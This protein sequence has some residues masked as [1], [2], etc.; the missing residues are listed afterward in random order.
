MA[1]TD[2]AAAASLTELWNAHRSAVS[3]GEGVYLTLRAAIAAGTLKPGD[4]LAEPPIAEALGISRTPIREALL[5]LE[6]Q[7]L[8]E[9]TVG[10]RLIV[11]EVTAEEIL[12]VY[13]VREVLTAL[14]AR[15]AAE[16][17]STSDQV[18]LRR[19]HREMRWALEEG[20]IARMATLNFE[21]HDTLC[22]A[23]RNG[24]LLAT[25]RS[26]HDTHQRYPGSTFS[27]PERAEQSVREHEQMLEAIAARDGDRAEKLAH[28]HIAG[29]REARIAMLDGTIEEERRRLAAEEARQREGGE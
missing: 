21:F 22:A 29:V 6:T 7:R 4:H 14:A 20:D 16:N 28:Q 11:S 9:R 24:F 2:P 1:A 5:R 23:S 8:V 17:A 19:L 27:I 10:R 26:A 13:A 18:R 25:L 3:A 12:D 15:L